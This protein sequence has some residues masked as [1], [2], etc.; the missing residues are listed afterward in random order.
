[1]NNYWNGD[2]QLITNDIEYIYFDISK[3]WLNFEY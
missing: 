1:M 2:I 3:K